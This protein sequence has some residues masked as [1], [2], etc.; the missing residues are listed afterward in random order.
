VGGDLIMPPE[1][2]LKD[3]DSIPCKGGTCVPGVDA[4]LLKNIVISLWDFGT[5]CTFLGV[6][7]PIF[8]LGGIFQ[9]HILFII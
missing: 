9:I 1:E 6:E 8:L 5:A 3:E 2:L 4:F 7:S